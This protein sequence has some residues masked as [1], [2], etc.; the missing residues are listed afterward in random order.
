MF[1]KHPRHRGP[2][3]KGDAEWGLSRHLLSGTHGQDHKLECMGH[4]PAVL[5]SLNGDERLISEPCKWKRI[6]AGGK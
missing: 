6:F 4:A 3:G 1:I 2:E 5:Q